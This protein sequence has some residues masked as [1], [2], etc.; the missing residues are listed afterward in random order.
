M[1]REAAWKGA[2]KRMKQA[3]NPPEVKSL[4]EERD[5]LQKEVYKL[6]LEKEILEQATDLI[7]KSPASIQSY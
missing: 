6:R 3:S 2:S 5:F 1:E 7:K 4:K